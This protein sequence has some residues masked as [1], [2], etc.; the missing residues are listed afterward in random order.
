MRTVRVYS[1]EQLYV[2]TPASLYGDAV[3]HI[4][5]VL[6][7]RTG[8]PM[9]LFDGSGQDYLGTIKEI[10]KKMVTVELD[11]ARLAV[12]ESPL[13]I[14]LWHGICRGG[15]MDYVVQKAT[16]L[17]VHAIQPVFTTRGAV[18]LDKQRAQKKSGTG[19][20]LLSA[21]R[22]NSDAAGCPTSVN[23]AH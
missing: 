14:T 9:I 7:M 19:R 20:K 3:Q 21:L 16:E 23:R 5:R 4:V 15:R 17:G 2:G 6:R 13:R 22:N 1:E 18:R 8:D 12:T 11:E 10:S